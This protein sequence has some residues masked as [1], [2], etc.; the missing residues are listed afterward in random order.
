MSSFQIAP[1]RQHTIIQHGI[2]RNDEYYWM[3]EREDPEVSK[4]LQTDLE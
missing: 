2:A 3:R 4:Y 1:K